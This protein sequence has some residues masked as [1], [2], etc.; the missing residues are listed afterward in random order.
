MATIGFGLR[1]TMKIGVLSDTHLH[2][3]EQGNEL[4]GRLLAGPFADVDAIL[5][6]G[7]HVFSDLDVCFAPIPWYSVRGNM[8]TS[9]IDIAPHKI[10]SLAGVRI[11]L[12]H[13]WGVAAQ[14]ERNV[15]D[16]FAATLPDCL[17]FGHTHIPLCRRIGK[18]LLFNP[19]SATNP[20]GGYCPS[21]GIIRL[22]PYIS[23]EI[24]ALV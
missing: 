1:S 11:G 22:Q 16:F 20:R 7:D 15:L 19:G 21:V 2:T 14:V 23:G 10:V 8:D 6:A 12:I 9:R 4:A 24:V 17:V 5:H 13:G 3:M 18:T